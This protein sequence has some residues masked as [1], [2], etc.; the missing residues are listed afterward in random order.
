R[1]RAV[2]DPELSV[3]GR[4]VERLDDELDVVA[5]EEPEVAGVTRQ[6][7][8]RP[9]AARALGWDAPADPDLETPAVQAESQ[10]VGDTGSRQFR[11]RPGLDRVTRRG[12]GG[13][14]LAGISANR[15]QERK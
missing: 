15:R 11:R 6:R 3:D 9:H 5:R 13:R 7:Q 10:R 2:E 14:L 8:G 12:A 4:P 1:E